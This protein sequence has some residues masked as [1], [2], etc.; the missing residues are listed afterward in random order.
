[1]PYGIG[2]DIG[3]SNIRVALANGGGRII[4]KIVENT[5]RSGNHLTIPRVI[6]LMISNLLQENDISINETLSIGIGSIGPLDLNRGMILKTANLPFK[7]IPLVSYLRDHFR[8]NVILVNDAVAGA[9]GEHVFGAGK[10][11]ENLVYITMSTGIGAG[12]YV[13]GKPLIGKDGNAH[14]VGHM[15]I[16]PDGKLTCGCGGKGHWEAY[17]SG[18]GIPKLAKFIISTKTER[19]IKESLIFKFTNGNLDSITAKIIYDAY[20]QNDKI[21]LE[22]IEQINKYNTIGIANIV[23][24][25]DPSLITI[26]GAIALNNPDMIINP[27]KQNLEK[28]IINRPP[29]IILTPLGE[30]VVLYGAIALSLGF[31]EINTKLKI[32]VK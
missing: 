26:G 30:D 31:E 6:S 2:V 5:P 21:A 9:I 19:E 17:S 18:S 20:K 7:E 28:Y 22:I 27:I 12:V 29:E 16:D 23:N 10:M 11:Y 32:K 15:V 25:Y 14:E 4:S 3:A 1:L 13:D 24:L 8:T